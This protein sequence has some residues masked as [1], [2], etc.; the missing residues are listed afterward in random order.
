MTNAW[1]QD[2]VSQP[3]NCESNSPFPANACPIDGYTT[4][5]LFAAWEPVKNKLDGLRLDFSINNITDQKYYQSTS[6][7]LPEEGRN[8]RVSLSYAF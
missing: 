3:E 1:S 5:D 2:K 6:S 8:V 4:L 7:L